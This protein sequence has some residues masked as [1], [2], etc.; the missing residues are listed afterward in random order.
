MAGAAVMAVPSSSRM[1]RTSIGENR[2]ILSDLGYMI[3]CM[4][5]LR[6]ESPRD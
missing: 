3:W 1:I 5:S 6:N 2:E 4:R